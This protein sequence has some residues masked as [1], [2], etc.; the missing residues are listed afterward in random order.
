MYHRVTSITKH[1]QGFIN[2]PY[3]QLISKY[4]ID[5]KILLRKGLLETEFYGNLVYKFRRNTCN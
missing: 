1:F 4:N 3:S 2:N 5:L